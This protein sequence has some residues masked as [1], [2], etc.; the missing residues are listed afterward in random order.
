MRSTE[1]VCCRHSRPSVAM[2]GDSEAPGMD[3]R[4]VW[5]G[6]DTPL[7]SAP[8]PQHPPPNVRKTSPT[9]EQDFPPQPL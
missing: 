3:S 8:Q 2:D 7:T 6:D 1:E 9:N 5:S 4:R